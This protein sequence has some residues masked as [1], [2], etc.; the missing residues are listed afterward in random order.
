MLNRHQFL[1]VL[2]KALLTFAALSQQI[3]TQLVFA[4]KTLNVPA[5]I[6]HLPSIIIISFVDDK[7]HTSETHFIKCS[8]RLQLGC[9]QEVHEIY[10][11]VFHDSIKAT[12]A[13]VMLKELFMQDRFILIGN[14]AGWRFS[15]PPTCIWG[16]IYRFVVGWDWRD[17]SLLGAAQSRLRLRTSLPPM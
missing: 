6:I 8:G 12:E 9:I 11:E 15:C 10:K 2:A 3:G 17:D 1:H 4:A 7:T 5:E 16:L 14:G 13:T